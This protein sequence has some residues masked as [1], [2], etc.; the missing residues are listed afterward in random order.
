MKKSLAVRLS[1]RFM[2]IVAASLL[3]LSIIFIQLLRLSQKNKMERDLY[4]AASFLSE[5]LEL[6]ETIIPEFLDLPYFITFVVY[7][8]KSQEVYVTNDPFLPCLPLTQGKAKKY[9]QR[10]YFTD[11]DLNI[12]YCALECQLFGEKYI[13]ETAMD[14]QKEFSNDIPGQIA[15]VALIIFIPILIISFLL[16]FLIT[17]QTIKPV[18]EITRAAQ[19]MSSSN[20]ESLL[21]VSKNDDELDQL[22]KTF[23]SL[24][25]SLRKD[26]D[27]ERAFTSDVSH[28]LK[29]PVAGILGQA[30][31]LKRWGKDDPKQLESSLDMII[32]EANAMNSIITNLLQMSKLEHGIIKPQSEDV[33]LWS[34]FSRIKKEFAAINSNLEIVFD[35]NIDLSLKTDIELLHQ[36]LTAMIS[37][38][39]KFGA[40][41]INL[42]GKYDEDKKVLIQVEDNG[43]GFSEEVLPHIFERFYRG[44][45][46]HSRSAG[47]AGLGLSI[48]SVIIQSLGG[49]I[50]AENSPS[51]RGALLT[52]FL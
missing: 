13:V 11:G 19:K 43:P 34:L 47:G 22:A 35:E 32:T 30:N 14:I 28:E 39:I 45:A 9:F 48:S 2:I 36:V 3:M 31:L 20:L 41:K 37:N 24:F 16:S 6:Q 1:L 49:Q 26:F 5:Q 29:T 50:K 46:S 33:N 25:E 27:R 7:E 52:I 12:L 21:P 8:E 23:N 10:D 18:E 40:S 4:S 17:K 51:T 42:Y 44:D 38:S 15:K